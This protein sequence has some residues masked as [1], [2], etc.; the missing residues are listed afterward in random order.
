MPRLPQ[1]LA[2]LLLAAPLATATLATSAAIAGE[3][4]PNATPEATG[5]ALVERFFEMI[6]KDSPDR[7]LDAFL[8]P[9]FQICRADG[10]FA[11]KQE[12][13]ANP[14]KVESFTIAEDGFRAYR[15]G[16]VLTVRFALDVDERIDGGDVAAM[17]AMRSGTFLEA[18]GRWRLVSWCNFNPAAAGAAAA[19]PS[20]EEIHARNLESLGGAA[21]LAA[22]RH[23][24]MRGSMQ[25]PAMGIRGETTSRMTLPDLSISQTELP[26]I[27]RIVEGV[28][29]EV[30]WSID[31]IR[32]PSLAEP[33][34]VAQRRLLSRLANNLGDPRDLF[35]T[36]EVV[37]VV[38][39]AGTP[40][41]EVRLASK[42]GGTYTILYRV[43]NG[44]TQGMRMTMKS[45]L[46]DLPVEVE[47]GEYK[48][49]GEVLWPT[50]TTT[51]VMGQ[52]QAMVIEE[53]SFDPIDPSVFELPPAIK[54][55][56]DAGGPAAEPAAKDGQVQP[57]AGEQ[58]RRRRRPAATPPSP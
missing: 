19:L 49:F 58:P 11:N 57:P 38:E 56:A 24:T 43:D 22:M 45:S 30:G 9:A 1:R 21:A 37:G 42:E 10:S 14:A 31:P 2:C 25:M 34:E 54:A 28:N 39:F 35:D 40:C 8:S 16:P 47:I 41:H 32:G 12:Y 55:L 18:D 15:D 5:R 48:T 20:F 7:E 52:E 36:V 51:R 46:G 27:G 3:I 4:P 26:G 17:Q 53:I 33:Q 23:V 13:L 29:G 6:S 50:R 44:L